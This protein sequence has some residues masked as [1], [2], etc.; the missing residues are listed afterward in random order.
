MPS[1]SPD[2]PVSAADRQPQ[3]L[4]RLGAHYTAIH[5]IYWANVAAQSVYAVV[6]LQSR[7]FSNMLIGIIIA[8][9]ALSS[10][11]LQPMVATFVDKIKKRIPIK[12]FNLALIVI[13]FVANL[14]LLLSGSSLALAI[15]AFALFGCSENILA[16]MNDALAIQYINGGYPINYSLARGTGSLVFAVACLPLAWIVR[17]YSNDWILILH[18]ILLVTEFLIVLPFQ[19]YPGPADG[20]TEKV[21]P[22]SGKQKSYW[23]IISGSVPLMVYLVSSTC[24]YMSNNTIYQYMVNILT[25]VGGRKEDVGLAM[26]IQVACQFP[27]SLIYKR[28]V[29]YFGV[30]RLLVFSYFIM[31]VRQVLLNIAW[32]PTAVQGFLF[33]EL[34]A[35]SLMIPSEVFYINQIVDPEDV[36]KGQSLIRIVPSGIGLLLASL[37]GGSLLDASGATGL[38]RFSLI[39]ATSGFLIM[40][41]YMLIQSRRDRQKSLNLS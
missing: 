30:R 25:N 5:G 22:S 20:V 29:R 13:A 26:F 19:N 27:M 34:I 37:I 35:G 38:L 40:A 10:V 31:A 1:D 36:V 41:A 8:A 28:V 24:I 32:S 23:K 33:I 14:I 11:I 6:I 3:S 39:L 12:Y 17:N 9:R 7:G 15:L 21:R 2:A 4:R 16:A 18:G